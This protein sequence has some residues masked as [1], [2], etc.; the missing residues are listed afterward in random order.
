MKTGTGVSSKYTHFSYG[1]ELTLDINNIKI[2]V[3]ITMLSDLV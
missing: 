3:E 1:T 2:L